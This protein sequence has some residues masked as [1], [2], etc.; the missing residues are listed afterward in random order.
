MHRD[1]SYSNVMVTKANEIKV[2][3]FGFARNADDTNYDTEYKDIQR[4]FVIPNEKYTFRT[5][6]YCIGAILYTLITGNTFDDLDFTLI[7]RSDCNFKLKAAT[8]ICLSLEPEKR[9]PDAIELKK[10]VQKSDTVVLPHNF[11]LDFFKKLLNNNV[12]LHFYPQNLP[13]K[14][15]VT[16]WLENK[17]REHINSCVFQST[18]N[19][20]SLLNHLSGV[21]KITYYKNINY[22][23]DKTQFIE[24][25]NFYDTLSVDMKDLFIR[26][27][28]LIILEVSQDDDL[29]LPFN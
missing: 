21:T 22:D 28:L 3:D 7:D 24:L 13:T 17:Y 29:D 2:L 1:I 8:K 4:K 20:V 16:E 10:F 23:L 15:T 12:I 18:L 9:F 11:S 25:L 26:N 14:E 6:V 27:I 19:L 5:E